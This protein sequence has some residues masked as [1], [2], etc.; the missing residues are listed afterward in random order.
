MLGSVVQ[1][2]LS[3]PRKR[4][5]MEERDLQRCKPSFMS[6]RYNACNH[7]PAFIRPDVVKPPAY[8]GAMTMQKFLFALLASLLA[9]VCATQ[10]GA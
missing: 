9:L 3:P 6:A 8:S 10:A 5:E 7:F 4:G 1:V 2:H